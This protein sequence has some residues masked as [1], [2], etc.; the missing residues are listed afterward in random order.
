MVALF[1]S[2][3]SLFTR[4]RRLLSSSSSRPACASA[5]VGGGT[6]GAPPLLGC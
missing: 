4:F 6:L 1:F 3:R 5:A 2:R